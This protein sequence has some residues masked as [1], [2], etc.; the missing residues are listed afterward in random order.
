MD[1]T[2]E[3]IREFCSDMNRI[4]ATD[5]A[6]Q[7]FNERGIKTNDVIEGILSGEIIE[8]YPDDYPYP[9]CLVLGCTIN[10]RKIH[11]VCGIGDNKLYIITAYFPNNEKWENDFKTRKAVSK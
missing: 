6:R 2:I 10:K 8:H 5:H 11:I 9:S 4:V 1:I 3:E 7:K